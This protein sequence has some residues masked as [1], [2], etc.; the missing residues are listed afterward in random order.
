[1]RCNPGYDASVSREWRPCSEESPVFHRSVPEASGERR[2]PVLGQ[3]WVRR[4]GTDAFRWPY[5][6]AKPRRGGVRRRVSVSALAN[7]GR[8]RS[9]VAIRSSI[10]LVSGTRLKFIKPSWL[11]DP[12]TDFTLGTC[13]VVLYQP[14]ASSTRSRGGLGLCG[15]VDAVKFSALQ[16]RR[17]ARS[18][19]PAAR[20]SVSRHW[21]RPPGRLR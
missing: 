9:A 8:L 1:M 12:Q 5:G 4:K 14:I 15:F 21:L 3:P 11:Y 18:S 10:E 20:R 13:W 16:R 6:R 2:L 17:V 7:S 19:R